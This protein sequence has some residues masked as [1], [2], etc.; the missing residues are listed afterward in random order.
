MNI[1]TSN[2]KQ[3]AQEILEAGYSNAAQSFSGIAQRKVNIET[4][5][6]EITTDCSKKLSPTKE[7]ELMLVTT[8]I[9]GDVN[10][11]SYFLLNEEESQAIYRAC[12]PPSNDAKEQKIMEE[13]II[14]EIDNIISAAV[15]TEFSNRL[16]MRIFGD[17]P[18]LTVGLASVIGQQISEE[19]SGEEEGFYLFANT[20]FRF[21][22]NT[23]LQPQF[24]W[25]LPWNFLQRI[26][27][28]TQETSPTS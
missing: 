5:T 28:Y 15:I 16:N 20:Y 2:E 7:G 18:V 26:K 12:L 9:I 14:K 19:F 4:S 22:D 24:F 27:A 25:K 8:E 11:K 17:V 1:L 21:E 3:V 6:L 23:T 10:G 13:A